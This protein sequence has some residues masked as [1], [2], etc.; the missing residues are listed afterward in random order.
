MDTIYIR[1]RKFY[2]VDPRISFLVGFIGSILM[3]FIES[4]FAL[5]LAFILGLTWCVYCGKWKNAAV[6]A[7][8]FLLLQLWTDALANGEGGKNGSFIIMTIL[9]SRF[10]VIGSFVI[11]IA[12]ADIGTLV[13]SLK[14]LKLPKMVVMSIA[15]LMRFIPTFQ[16]EY[17]NVRTSQ[18]F[19]GI[20][21][22]IINVI[23]HP[24]TFY[25]TLIVPLAIRIM[26]VSDEL[27]ASAMLRGAD[28][29]GQNSC[30][31]DVRISRLDFVIFAIFLAGITCCIFINY[32]ILL[33][34][35]NI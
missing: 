2:E 28:K 9:F 30:F 19:R 1:K 26:R 3:L 32:G 4:G 12:S 11:P 33:G 20:G 5:I 6:I 25:E 18:K 10:M 29:K 23:L 17:R 8:I 15:I 21:R 13:G 35:L 14:K 24:I 22:S 34:G 27:S 16:E 7:G 31:R